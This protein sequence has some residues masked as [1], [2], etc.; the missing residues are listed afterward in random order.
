VSVRRAKAGDCYLSVLNSFSGRGEGGSGAVVRSRVYP[1]DVIAVVLLPV[2]LSAAGKQH[3][4]GNVV[5]AGR[6]VRI[7]VDVGL[8]IGTDR[9]SQ[10]SE[11]SEVPAIDRQL[12]ELLLIHILVNRG[13]VRLKQRK[14]VSYVHRLHSRTRRHHQV[15]TLPLLS[16]QVDRLRFERPKSWLFGMHHVMADCQIRKGIL[17]AAVRGGGLCLI[18]IQI[19]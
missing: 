14:C 5:G 16:H 18:S 7:R 9:R 15:Q 1:V 13:M 10:N 6:V 17:P 12:L 19:S 2:D 4:A 8:R 11:R 3:A